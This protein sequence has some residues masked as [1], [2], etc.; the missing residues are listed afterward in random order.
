MTGLS[1]FLEVLGGKSVFLSFSPL[2]DFLCFHNY[3]G[4]CFCKCRIRIFFVCTFQL[5][6]P[7]STYTTTFIFMFSNLT[8]P[9]LKSWFLRHSNQKVGVIHHLCTE[10]C[11]CNSFTHLKMSME[12]KFKRKLN[13]L[14][15]WS[16]MK[17]TEQSY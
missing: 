15:P 10:F 16:T 14:H 12:L 13:V 5:L 2:L 11:A 17:I 6:S 7:R 3:L 4:K 8:C 9:K 1:S